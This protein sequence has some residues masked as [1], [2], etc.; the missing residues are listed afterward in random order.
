LSTRPGSPCPGSTLQFLARHL[1]QRRRETG[2]RWRCLPARRQALLPPPHLRC[3]DP[4][5]QLAAA[6]DIDT[7]YRRTREAVEVLAAVAPSL[8][9]V[10]TT[11]AAKA[12]VIL[13][14]TL[15]PIRSGASS[16]LRSRCRVQSTT[17]G[18]P[19]PTTSPPP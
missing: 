9:Q 4:Y 10:A 11:A 15:L 12:F 19:A 6:F 3:G 7:V 16:G 5:S 17:S 1:R 13:D 14:G 8:E 18:P 2:S